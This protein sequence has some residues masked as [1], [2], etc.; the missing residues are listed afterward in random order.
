V[1][2]CP[3]VFGLIDGFY[4]QYNIPG[5]DSIVVVACIDFSV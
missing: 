3:R 1:V 2:S 5:S 4:H